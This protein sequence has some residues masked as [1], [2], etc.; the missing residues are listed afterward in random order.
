MR[1]HSCGTS[2]ALDSRRGFGIASTLTQAAAHRKTKWTCPHSNPISKWGL[3]FRSPFH[4]GFRWGFPISVHWNEL[5]FR[6]S[7]RPQPPYLQNARYPVAELPRGV[8]FTRSGDRLPPSF[9]M[10]ST[11]H[12]AVHYPKFP[13]RR[14][15]TRHRHP[16]YQRAIAGLSHNR[17]KSCCGGVFSRTARL[18]SDAWRAR[19]DMIGLL[20]ALE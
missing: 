1:W 12:A 16:Y 7:I 20:T 17:E 15:R 10:S 4:N 5:V 14:P 18:R 6:F 8:V 9:V 11:G 3:K 13:P 19:N 2:G